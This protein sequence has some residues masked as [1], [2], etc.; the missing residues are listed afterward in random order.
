MRI[1]KIT[2]LPRLLKEKYIKGVDEERPAVI[3]VN[4]LIAS[5]AVND[6][7]ARLH[8]FRDDSNEDI[9]A[10]IFSL[11]QMRFAGLNDKFP[12]DENLSKYTG[13]G[14]C[15]PLIGVTGLSEVKSDV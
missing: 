4:T 14:D 8:P 13:V 5:F 11:S 9:D 6:F 10:I 3:S 1:C 7:L 12:I 15:S 2:V